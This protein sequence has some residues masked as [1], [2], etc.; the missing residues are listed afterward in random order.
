VHREFRIKE[1]KDKI[2]ELEKELEEVGKTRGA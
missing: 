2:A 1:L